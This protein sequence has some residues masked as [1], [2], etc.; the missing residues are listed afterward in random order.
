MN[1]DITPQW[2]PEPPPGNAVEKLLVQGATDLSVH[3]RLLRALWKAEV[4][5]LIEY[6]P[7][8]VE[9]TMELQNGSPMPPFLRVQDDTG[10]FVPVFSSEE[11]AD[12]CIDKNAKDKGPKALAIMPGE[13]FFICMNQ[14][15]T[16]VVL[17]PGM[18]HRLLL[19]Q[20]AVAAMVSGE[21][22]HARPHHGEA[23]ESYLIGVDCESLPADFR[24]GLR[25][26]CDAT[27]VPIAVYMFLEGDPQTHQ[28][29]MRQWRI[30]LRLR[31]EENDF[32]NDLGLLARK[33]LP[34]SVDLNIAT[35]TGDDAQ[36]LDFLQKHT[37][38]WPVL[39]GPA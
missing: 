6:H 34:K 19:K 37:P 39:A 24:D 9:Q 11:V 13:A 15:K 32:Y 36:A 5:A 29:D 10:I 23:R 27:P 33:L 3:G 21:L 1:D 22:R 12:Y 14:L 25:R 7:E 20:E 38:L 31:N 35:V 30:M 26:F 8:V 2:R 17:N 16:D 18:T 28:P 4:C